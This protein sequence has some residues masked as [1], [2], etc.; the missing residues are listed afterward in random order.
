MHG[1]NNCDYNDEDFYYDNDND[2]ATMTMTMSQDDDN[3]D[4][5]IVEILGVKL[6]PMCTT[7]KR[8]QL[9]TTIQRN[10]LLTPW[11]DFIHNDHLINPTQSRKSCVAQES[12]PGHCITSN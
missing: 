5:D 8:E 4:N 1:G 10:V 12:N 3:D 2:N 6:P 9:T 7:R 11:Q